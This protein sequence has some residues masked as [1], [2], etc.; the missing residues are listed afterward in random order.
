MSACVCSAEAR[1]LEEADKNMFIKQTSETSLQLI[2]SHTSAQSNHS[3]RVER[4]AELDCCEAGEP[5]G[6]S[7]QPDTSVETKDAGD[8]SLGAN[9]NG[10]DEPPGNDPRTGTLET[11]DGGLA[12]EPNK[13]ESASQLG[14]RMLCSDIFVN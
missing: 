9:Q 1:V 4:P 8:A 14:V 3:G 6:V 12:V 2:D 11:D 7:P 10:V 5:D 13:E